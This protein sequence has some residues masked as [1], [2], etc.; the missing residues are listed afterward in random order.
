M[1]QQE[2]P[3][4]ETEKGLREARREGTKGKNAPEGSQ[5]GQRLSLFLSKEQ[6]LEGLKALLLS[7]LYWPHLVGDLD[8]K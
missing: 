3:G 6:S 8:T 7:G 4:E 5:V 2:A 1:G